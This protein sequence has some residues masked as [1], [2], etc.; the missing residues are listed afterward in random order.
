MATTSANLAGQDPLTKAEAIAAAFPDVAVYQGEGWE[1]W[2]GIPSTVVAWTSQ[3]WEIRR[4][5]QIIFDK[6]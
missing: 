4:Q 2:S 5:G 3:G 1:T 6:P